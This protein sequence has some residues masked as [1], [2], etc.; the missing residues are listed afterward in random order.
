MNI[1]QF[2][3]HLM[4]LAELANKDLSTPM[5]Q[6]WWQ[7][8]GDLPDAV[9][10]PAFEIAKRKSKYFPTPSD[11]DEIIQS[12]AAKDG[13]IVNGEAAWNVLWRDVIS[14]CSEASDR[15]I[16]ERLR[17]GG[18]GYAWPNE[19]ARV[20]VKDEMRTTIRALSEMHPA[21]L[22]KRREAFIR[23]YDAGQA[24]AQAVERAEQ[25]IDAPNVRRIGA[26]GE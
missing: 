17:N 21:E 26:V 15:M 12:I 4:L 13:T 2:K 20:V 6:Y 3:G 7:T 14:Q 5:V 10:F 16:A 25:A 22:A 1:A 23:H 19:R 9:L 24:V 18:P 11:F 8:Y